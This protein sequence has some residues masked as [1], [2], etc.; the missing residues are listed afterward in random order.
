MYKSPQYVICDLAG[1]LIG[2]KFVITSLAV[3]R[4]KPKIQIFFSTHDSESNPYCPDHWARDDPPEPGTTMSLR[5]SSLPRLLTTR[6]AEEEEKSK[7]ED[8]RGRGK[9]HGRA[10]RGRSM[11]ARRTRR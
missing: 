6:E 9:G 5:A 7:T 1:A 10:K 8:A 3:Q 4:T 11:A 2:T